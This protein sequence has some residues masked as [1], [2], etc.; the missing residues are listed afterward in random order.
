MSHSTGWNLRMQ[1][2]R[3]RRLMVKS[4]GF[5]TLCRSVSLSPVLVTGQL[6]FGG[7]KSP[8]SSAQLPAQ[9]WEVARLL[10]SAQ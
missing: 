3:P 9:P 4:R 7:A 2:C 5:S 1:N 6:C 8:P 10:L